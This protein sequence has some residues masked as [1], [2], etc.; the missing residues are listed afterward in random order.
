[1]MLAN[2]KIIAQILGMVFILVFMAP[3]AVGATEAARTM[4]IEEAV[5]RALHNNANIRRAILE[6]DKNAFF[7]IT[8]A[9]EVK[10]GRN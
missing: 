8:D 5:N 1:M 7:V 10:G 3:S 9:Y 2:R 4:T 6:I